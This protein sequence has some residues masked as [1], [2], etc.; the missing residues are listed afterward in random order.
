MNIFHEDE[1][2]FVVR[3]QVKKSCILL[4]DC[5]KL[6]SIYTEQNISSKKLDPPTILQCHNEKDHSI[7]TCIH[8]HYHPDLNSFQNLRRHYEFGD[9]WFSTTDYRLDGLESKPGGDEIFR[10][11]RPA[12]GPTQ[13]PDKL[14][15]GLSRG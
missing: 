2:S 3:L 12:L 9:V 4:C 10:P 7:N 13:P 6:V 8:H 5:Y 15:P 11:S 1:G 14:V